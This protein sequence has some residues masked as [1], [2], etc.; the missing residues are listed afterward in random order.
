MS[1]LDDEDVEKIVR[2]MR[3]STCERECAVE[4][5]PMHAKQHEV[6]ERWIENDTRQQERTEK[7]KTQ[8]MGWSIVTLLGG[9]G[10]GIYQAFRFLREYLR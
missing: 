3:S 2:A 5:I 6:L 1:T 9:V 7:I 8:V 10:T 4:S